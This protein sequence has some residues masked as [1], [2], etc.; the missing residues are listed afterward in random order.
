MNTSISDVSKFIGLIP[1]T[2]HLHLSYSN[3]YD[4]M[5]GSLGIWKGV[6]LLSEF[7]FCNSLAVRSWTNNLYLS[8]SGSSFIKLS[9]KF[10]AITEFKCYNVCVLITGNMGGTQ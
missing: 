2:Q 8:T 1:P 3:Y 5:I 7:R 9:Y 10:T 4:H 6:I